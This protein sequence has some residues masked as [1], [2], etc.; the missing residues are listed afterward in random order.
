MVEKHR[1]QQAK[2]AQQNR[3]GEIYR[4]LWTTARDL[5][6]EIET[7]FPQLSRFLTGYDLKHVYH[8][9]TKSLDLSRLIHP[10]PE[11]GLLP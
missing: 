7:T 3:E 8:P 9:E 6:P 2:L 11:T 1:K 10:H 4:Q 5:R